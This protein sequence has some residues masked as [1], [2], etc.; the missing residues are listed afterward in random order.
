MLMATHQDVYAVTGVS[1]LA[2]NVVKAGSRKQKGEAVLKLYAVT[3]QAAWVTQRGLT[4]EWTAI[5][6]GLLNVGLAR[7]VKHCAGIVIRTDK[8]FT[9]LVQ[10]S[11]T[12]MIQASLSQMQA[13]CAARPQ[14]Q[15]DLHEQQESHELPNTVKLCSL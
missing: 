1:I 5:Y 15:H 8:G 9:D 7:F 11:H 13:S 3:S 14:Y 6:L 10:L 12:S 4:D 2:R